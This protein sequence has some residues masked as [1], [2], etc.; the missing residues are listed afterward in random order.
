MY[1]RE[2]EEVLARHPAIVQVA[3][4]G[5]HDDYYSEEVHAAVILDPDVAV[6]SEELIEWSKK[7]LGSH[8]YPRHFHPWTTFPMGP[9]GKVLKREI[10]RSVAEGS[11][12]SASAQP[13][14][15]D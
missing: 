2:V 13:V 7:H 3:V 5:I 6:T 14:E 1:P 4:V 9:S 15:A 8:K 12:P 10:A 11:G